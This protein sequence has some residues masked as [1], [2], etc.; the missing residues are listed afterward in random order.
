MKRREGKKAKSKGAPL[1]M[2]TFS[3]LVT[4]ILVFFVLLFSV[5]QIDVIKLQAVAESFRERQIFQF[6]PSPVPFENPSEQTVID[7]SNSDTD[8]KAGN[9]D[10]INDNREQAKDET[11]TND[12]SQSED[13]SLE[14]LLTDV[15]DFLDTNDLNDVILAS[16]TERGVVL[17]LQ[18]NV[19]FNSG[20][21]NLLPSALPFLEKV[22]TLLSNIPNEVKVEGHTDNRPITT[23]K[24]PSNWELSAARSS[25]VIRYLL[26][27]NNLSPDRFVAVGYGDTAPV[28]PN[29][30][31]ENWQINRRVEIVIT[32]SDSS[33]E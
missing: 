21:A 32:N 2:V 11:T 13:E 25:S 7:R 31:P 28:V 23:A 15:Q 10:T 18:E 29:I 22:G 16:R 33:N 4:L 5:S 24:Y 20:D 17:V 19:L 9:E 12:Q 3:D 14:N 27:N 1:W 26:A 6:Y 8:T 30:S